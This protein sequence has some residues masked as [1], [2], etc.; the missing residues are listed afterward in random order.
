M[1]NNENKQRLPEIVQAIVIKNEA[2]DIKR[3]NVTTDA[4]YAISVSR[5]EWKFQDGR[6]TPKPANYICGYYPYCGYMEKSISPIATLEIKRIKKDSTIND[7]FSNGAYG[8]YLSSKS[9]FGLTTLIDILSSEKKKMYEVLLEKAIE[10]AKHV[11]GDEYLIHD[12]G[13]KKIE[14]SDYVNSKYSYP[15]TIEELTNK[16]FH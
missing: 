11:R 13:I 16:T 7:L 5:K 14:S 15:L 2:E 4:L 10:I 6:N 1:T 12:Y 9:H 8:I 3:Y